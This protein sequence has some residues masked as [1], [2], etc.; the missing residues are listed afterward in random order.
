MGDTRKRWQLWEGTHRFFWDGRLM[1]AR[2]FAIGLCS[3]SFMSALFLVWGV[4]V[5]PHLDTLTTLAAWLLYGVSMYL[6]VVVWTTDPGVIPS[7]RG[8]LSSDEAVAFAAEERSCEVNGVALPLK[9]CRTCHIFRPL[10]ASHCSTCDVCV[11]RFDHHCMWMGSCIGG[12]NYRLFVLFIN[13]LCVLGSFVLGATGVATHR[14]MAVSSAHDAVCSNLP[15]M[16]RAMWARQALCFVTRLTAY[17]PVHPAWFVVVLVFTF[18]VWVPFANYH[19]KLLMR[20]QTTYEYLKQAPPHSNVSN[21]FSRGAWHNT[22]EACCHPR[23]PSH[24]HSRAVLSEDERLRA[25][26]VLADKGAEKVPVLLANC[27]QD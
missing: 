25:E 7:N 18:G 26:R 1:L 10:R 27:K 5:C 3:I 9:W 23:P 11:E 21:P 24:L 12:R 2:D 8:H 13:S 17:G 19:L 16:P 14:A 6:F 20:N 4:F 15:Q 22:V